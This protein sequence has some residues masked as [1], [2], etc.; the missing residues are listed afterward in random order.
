MVKNDCDAS[1]F[2]V[3]VVVVS[4][5]VV[6]VVVVVVRSWDIIAVVVAFCCMRELQRE[7]RS[8]QQRKRRMKSVCLLVRLFF[9][10]TFGVWWWGVA[11]A[12]Q[13]WS[14]GNAAEL[15]CS[16]GKFRFTPCFEFCKGEICPPMSRV[17]R[18]RK[19]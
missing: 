1:S 14:F 12:D 19:R 11:S 9:L 17:V 2:V 13:V 10:K 5:H 18:R 16:L 3:V 7:I 15:L 4:V 8:K 6:V